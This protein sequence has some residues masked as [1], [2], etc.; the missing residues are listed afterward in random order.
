MILMIQKFYFLKSYLKK[1]L[2][3]LFVYIFFVDSSNA[4]FKYKLNQKI[5]GEFNITSRISI[6]LPKGEWKVIYRSGEHIFRG[7]HSYQVSLVQVS[8]NNVIKLF[9]IGKIEG[10]SVIMGYM[11]PIIVNSVFKPKR[12]GCVKRKYYTL[13]KYYKSSGITH[14]CVSIKHVDA[15]FELYENDDPNA[16][17]GYLVNWGEENN[18]NYS[19]VYLGYEV[20]IYIPR[21]ADR[22]LSLNY[23]ESPKNFDNYDPIFSSE[24]QSEFHPQNINNHKQAKRVMN[25]WIEYIVNHHGKVENGLKIK[26]KYKVKFDEEISNKTKKGENNSELVEMLEKL[27]ELYKSNVLTKEEFNKAKEKLINQYN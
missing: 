20:S 10:L 3:F 17:L 6:P 13:L 4:A 26:G 21:I 15:N 14:N 5:S 25:K 11:T 19:D 8:N 23:F 24:A 22:Y 9:E 27:N 12:N 1:F 16:N 7:I 2:L 18:L